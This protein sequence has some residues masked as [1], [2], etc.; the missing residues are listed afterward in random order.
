LLVYLL[1]IVVYV[2]AMDRLEARCLDDDEAATGPTG[3][4]PA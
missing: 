3:S 4:G 1:I 2:L